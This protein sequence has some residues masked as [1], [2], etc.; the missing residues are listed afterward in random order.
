MLDFNS[1]DVLRSVQGEVDESKNENDEVEDKAAYSED[2]I[3]PTTIESS[4]NV[5]AVDVTT[6][7]PYRITCSKEKFD[8]DDRIGCITYGFRTIEIE[9]LRN[10]RTKLEMYKHP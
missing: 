9:T 1:P 4:H 7:V 10:R 5:F 6:S 3:Q 2:I 8:F